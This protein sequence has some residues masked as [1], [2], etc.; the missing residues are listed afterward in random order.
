MDKRIKYVIVEDTSNTSFVFVTETEMVTNDIEKARH[1][2]TREQAEEV[3]KEKGWVGQT[4]IDAWHTEDDWEEFESKFE[5]VWHHKDT[6]SFLYETYGEDLERVRD[7]KNTYGANHV[8][9]L[10]EVD[11]V[12][13]ITPGMRLVDRI[14]YVLTKKPWEDG[15][16]DYLW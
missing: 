13:W 11:G 9:T 15:E 16:K 8:W 6:E 3:I 1:F 5:P 7:W 14:S 2:D 12:S 10:V 4:Y